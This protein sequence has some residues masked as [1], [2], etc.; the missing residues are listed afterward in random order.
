MFLFCSIGVK[1]GFPGPVHGRPRKNPGCPPGPTGICADRGSR[2]ENDPLS[3]IGRD[4]LSDLGSCGCRGKGFTGG[5]QFL[6]KPDSPNT[7]ADALRELIDAR[8]N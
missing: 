4:P 6:A 3:P 1:M 7:L 2:N 5:R 8:Q